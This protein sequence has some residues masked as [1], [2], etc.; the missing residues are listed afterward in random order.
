M[1]KLIVLLSIGVMVLVSS[2]G[3][4]AQSNDAWIPGLASFVLP[5]LGQFINDQTDKALLHFGIAIAL[6][7]G[8]YYVAAILPFSY[9]SYSL[10][11]LVHLAWGVYSGLDAY[12]VAKAQGFTL[13]L[14]DNGIGF[15]ISF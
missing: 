6:D 1:R 8:A 13:G 7:V 11:G 14:V 12:D 2:V 5:G 4:V 10:V 9:Y 15:A 3:A